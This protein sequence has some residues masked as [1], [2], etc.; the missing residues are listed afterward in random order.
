MEKIDFIVTW[1]DSNDPSW[2]E[3][4]NYYRP[5]KPIQ[6][7]GRFRDW[8]LFKYWFR[9]VEKYAPWVNKV[10]LVTNGKFP[11]WINPNCKK[12]VLVKHSDY[13]PEEKLPTFNSNT[14][15][16]YFNRIE[17]LS[18]HF[19]LFN[20]DIFINAPIQPEHYFR[21][22]L[23]CDF[24]FESPFR[25]PKYTDENQYGID[26]TTFC[27][28]AI[29]NRHFNRKKVICKAWKKWYGRHLWGKPVIMSLLMAGRSNF[30]NFVLLHLEQPFL[31]SVF[32]EV[33]EKERNVLDKSCT[34]F[35]ENTNLNQYFMRFWQF[36]S[37]RFHPVQKKG[38]TYLYYNEDIVNDLIKNMK[39]E[40]FQSICINDTP[41]ISEKMYEYAKKK[42][43]QAFEE[44]LP[45]HSIFEIE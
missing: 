34:R 17:G 24:N 19:V 40:H 16:L 33:W 43:Q 18:E 12:L 42:I 38:L 5:N 13:I 21:D 2:I 25:N 30:E 31:K 22:G 23:P 37:N 29:L 7:R 15:E 9:S 3:S 39:E 36:A 14:I 35:R 20:D 26:I 6:Y 27:D 28:I 8:N 32:D 45:K 41:N 11:D 4:Y 44:K 10:F 1:V